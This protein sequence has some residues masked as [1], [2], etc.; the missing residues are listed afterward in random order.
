MIFRVVSLIL[1]F[2]SPAFA[3]GAYLLLA[4]P[5]GFFIT[6]ILG[7]VLAASFWRAATRG[8]ASRGSTLGVCSVAFFLS[9]WFFLDF[10][11]D[12]Q[13]GPTCKQ[14]SCDNSPVTF[15]H[16]ARTVPSWLSSLSPQRRSLERLAS[17]L[18]S[19]GCSLQMSQD[20]C[21]GFPTY[22]LQNRRS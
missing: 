15:F 2:S 18:V 1:M 21:Y 22:G 17:P 9:L 14:R 8:L 13:Y 7:W 12:P 10:V 4:V 5:M 16:Q 20:D 6:P 19:P 11:A 3:D